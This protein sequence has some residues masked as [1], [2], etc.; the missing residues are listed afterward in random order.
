ME[1]QGSMT[2]KDKASNAGGFSKK[3]VRA[4]SFWGFRL[5]YSRV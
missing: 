2:H 4:A 5:F 1:V 3:S